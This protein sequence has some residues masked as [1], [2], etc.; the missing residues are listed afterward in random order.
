MRSKLAKIVRME[1]RLTTANRAFLVLTIL[2]PFLIVGVM[3]LPALMTTGRASMGNPELDIAVVGADP[4]WLAGVSPA[5]AGAGIRA[6][7]LDADAAELDARV[8]AGDLAGYVVLPPD[9][10][11]ATR[12]EYVAKNVSDFRVSAALSGV[13]GQSV[14]ALRLAKAGL[15]AA[16]IASLIRPPTVEARQLV[17]NGESAQQDFMTILFT[18]LIFAMLL[19]MTVLLYG[20]AI[21]RSVLTEKSGK[22]VEIMLS[23]V[24][25]LEL[26]F[27]KILGKGLASLLQYGI[28]VAM[29]VLFLRYAAPLLGLGAGLRLAV[30]PATL[31]FL[32][33][34]FLLDFFLYC[35]VYGALGSASEDDHHLGQ[36]AWPVIIFLVIPT[37]LI[38]PILTAPN[39]TLVVALTLFPLTGTV[40]MFLRILV[41]AA[42]AWQIWLCVGLLAVTIAAVVALAAKIFRVG[43]LMTGKRFKLGE[44]VR[45]VR[46]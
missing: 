4:Q 10:A 21:G 19:Y 42:P 14:V 9:L 3:V 17:K 43:L 2:G 45:W 16:E 13:I 6:V 27:G 40:V 33:L 15:P 36:L 38:S 1:Y 29:S 37:V 34:F 7:S 24:R 32:V 44:V 46:A 23:S 11:S 31:A 18:G 25:P 20:Q 5:L 28:W 41:G 12:I 30:T 8:L 39:S 35:S 26:L 22:T